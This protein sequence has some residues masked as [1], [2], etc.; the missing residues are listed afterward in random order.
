MKFYIKKNH[1]PLLNSKLYIFCLSIKL[2]H[3]KRPIYLIGVAS[4]FTKMS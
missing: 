3:K 4:P 1:E 2:K